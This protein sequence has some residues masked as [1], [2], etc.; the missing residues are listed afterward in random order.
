MDT[1]D[2]TLKTWAKLGYELSKVL[3]YGYTEILTLLPHIQWYTHR[4]AYIN[5]V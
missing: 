1:H 5:E 2:I 3:M 4:N